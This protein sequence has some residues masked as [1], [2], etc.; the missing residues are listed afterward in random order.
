MAEIKIKDN[1]TESLSK[2][3]KQISDMTPAFK[4]IADY[5]LSQT[6]LRY[7]DEKDPEGKKW[8]EPFTIRRDGNGGAGRRNQASAWG[9]VVKSNYHAAPPGFHFFDS[10]RGDKIMRDTGSLFASLSR[11]YGKNFALVGTDKEYA[12]E[13]QEGTGKRTARPFLG[14]NKKTFDNVKKVVTFY[15]KGIK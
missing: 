14:I 1:I 15:L 9:Y 13:N 11:A 7:R 6:K 3:S 8:V 4:S 5:E 12:K 2:L 10:A